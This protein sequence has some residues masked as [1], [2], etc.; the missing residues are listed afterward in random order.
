MALWDDIEG[1]WELKS[2]DYLDESGNEND[3]S[4][5]GTAPTRATG[6]GGGANKALLLNDGYLEISDANQTGLDI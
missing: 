1:K 6:M 5:N 4:L 2:L 3:L